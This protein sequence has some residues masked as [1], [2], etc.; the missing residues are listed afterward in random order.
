MLIGEIID[1]HSTNPKE[2]HLVSLDN[3]VFPFIELKERIDEENLTPKQEVYSQ[4][5]IL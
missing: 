1:K 3:Q 2:S 4:G 5:M